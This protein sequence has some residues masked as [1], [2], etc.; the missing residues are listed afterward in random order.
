MKIALFRN[1]RFPML[2]ITSRHADSIHGTMS[3]HD[4]L[5]LKKVSLA[6]SAGIVALFHWSHLFFPLVALFPRPLLF[7]Q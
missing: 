1:S 2:P 6:P 7:A 4:H 3:S 5:I